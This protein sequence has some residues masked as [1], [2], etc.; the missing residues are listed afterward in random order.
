[1][2]KID[3][4]GKKIGGARK[5]LWADRNLLK[6][7]LENMSDAEKKKFVKKANVWKKPNYQELYDSGLP[8]EVVYFIKNI[9]DSLP[10][11][12]PSIDIADNYID[13]VAEV[14]DYVMNIKTVEEIPNLYQHIKDNYIESTG[15][16]SIR[17]TGIASGTLDNGNKVLKALRK[18]V[19]QLSQEIR[20]HQF[21]YT[22][23][24]KILSSYSIILNNDNVKF[25][26]D[27]NN[28]T[29]ICCRIGEY[30]MH[31]Y[32][33]QND[34]FKNEDNYSKGTYFV[35]YGNDIVL[36]NIATLEE[37]KKQIIEYH[38]EKY[39]IEQT[40]TEKAKK[41]RKK[42]F[43]PPQLEH[44]ER[45]GDE[46]RNGHTIVGNDMLEKFGFLGGEFGN[47]LNDNDRQTN[48]N[49]SYDAFA[50]LSKALNISA[51]DIS[52]GGKLNIAYGARGHSSAMAHY[53][54]LYNVINLTKMKGAGSLA[55]E[56][57]HAIDSY[58][59]T[60]LE[61]TSGLL[62]ETRN[63]L[64]KPL[65]SS[66]KYKVSSSVEENDKK[67]TQQYENEKAELIKYM[68]NWTKH[69]NPSKT[70]EELNMQVDLLCKDASIERVTFNDIRSMCFE[71]KNIEIRF[72]NYCAYKM[73]CLRNTLSN[74]GKLNTFETQFYT[75]AKKLDEVY[76]RENNGY[77][78]SDAEMLARAF[79]CYV[80]D[81]IKANNER[82]DY[83]VGHAQSCC[84]VISKDEVI[85]GYPTEEER[86]A[87]NHE[88]DKF[89]EKVKEMN[90]LH[91]YDKNDLIFKNKVSVKDYNFEEDGNYPTSFDQIS[92]FDMNDTEKP[93]EEKENELV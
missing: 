69:Y 18:S 21:L 26:L 43:I 35:A 5:D 34:E 79:A 66:M 55:H 33:P 93:T 70:Q 42:K 32:H 64:L 28:N 91:D 87:I 7:D 73:N 36:K 61:N 54:P 3:D 85:R 2:P 49:M 25:N 31:F 41:T 77:W 9:R 48:L 65:I 24:E 52:L 4:F 68:L 40:P 1:M 67:I 23:E 30:S 56:W 45:I 84:C 71:G 11:A 47:W 90:Y 75:D 38:K 78:S 19:S 57:F 58:L 60:E 74:L 86:K 8:R 89:F 50:D 51:K 12:T 16:Y 72:D 62:S 37:A 13:F 14:R 44:I 76:S 83:L 53:E 63:E 10:T 59:G 46:L 39:Q 15:F 80:Y 6:A 27:Y 81:K 92:I 20:K 22:E 29:E 82:N 88:F 17:A